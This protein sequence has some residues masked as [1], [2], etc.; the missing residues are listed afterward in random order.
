MS[1]SVCKL[2]M[3]CSAFLLLGGFSSLAAA[4]PLLHF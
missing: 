4:D 3:V 1:N 2:T